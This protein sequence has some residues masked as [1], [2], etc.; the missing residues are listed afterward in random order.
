[1][2]R[3]GI[4]RL[5][6][7]F[8]EGRMTSA[9]IAART[10]M[11][12]AR[13]ESELGIREKRIG[14]PG[15]SALD[16]AVSAGRKLLEGIDP[17]S[18]DM[19]I[20]A[21]S[22]MPDYPL[23]WGVYSV[24]E[25]LG[26]QN[27][28]TLELRYGCISSLHALE[29]A[30]SYLRA[31]PR[32]NRAVVIGAEGYH[33]DAAFAD[34]GHPGN[35]PMFIFGDGAAAA[36]VETDRVAELTNVLHE[37]TFA[38]DSAGLGEILVPAGGAKRFTSAE[39]VAAGLNA[40]RATPPDPQHMKRFGVRYVQRYAH[41]VREALAASG[42]SDKPSFLLPNQ[43][44]PGLMRLVLTKLGL[45]ADQTCVTMGEYGHVGTADILFALETALAANRLAPGDVAAIVSSGIGFSWGAAA[46]EML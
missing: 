39:T 41:V 15:E 42:F 20:Y 36:L 16:F 35:E 33:F 32:L 40:S 3:V 10:G 38:V 19:V 2:T 5:A 29:V 11:E 18:I 25:L 4:T 17:A 34:Y 45:T 6:S 43:L 7:H 44:K 8:P 23:H 30:R 12:Q 37:F 24:H 46:L 9:D 1:M 26:L 13:V 14:A 31:N 28:R 21:T 22:S 27:A